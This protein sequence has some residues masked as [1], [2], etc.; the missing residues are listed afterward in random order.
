MQ[1]NYIIRCKVQLNP[2]HTNHL[3][4][5]MYLLTNPLTLCASTCPLTYGS[6]VAVETMYV[7][8]SACMHVQHSSSVL[9]AVIGTFLDIIEAKPYCIIGG[10]KCLKPW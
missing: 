7:A 10:F 2:W 5:C 9:F 4:Q 1:H 8:R 6:Q 3:R